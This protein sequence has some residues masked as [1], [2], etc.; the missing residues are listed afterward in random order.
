MN[1]CQRCRTCINWHTRICWLSL[2][3]KQC[4]KSLFNTLFI[5]PHQ[6]SKKRKK[7]QKL[8]QKAKAFQQ[9]RQAATT[10]EKTPLRRSSRHQ[11]TAKRNYC[12]SGVGHLHRVRNAALGSAVALLVTIHRCQGPTSSHFPISP[13]LSLPLTIHHYPIIIFEKAKVF[14]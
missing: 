1:F 11:E 6:D 7:A 14:T 3:P 8:L 9:S 4:F 2:H 10:E 13:Q 5:M 12:E